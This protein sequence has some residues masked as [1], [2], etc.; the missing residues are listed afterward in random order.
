VKIPPYRFQA[1]LRFRRYQRD[2]VRGLL[3][4]ALWE[5]QSREAEIDQLQSEQGG[6]LEDLHRATQPGMLNVD[7]A[8][9]RR[10]HLGQLKLRLN[11]AERRAKLAR[12]QVELCRKTLVLADQKVKSL[13]NIEEQDRQSYLRELERRE[14][15]ERE[16]NWLSLNAYER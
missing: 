15:R 14:S 8:V 4:E 6:A 10:I 9:M 2:H 3:A 11:D 13:E 7:A 16:D 12:E 5:L 1:P